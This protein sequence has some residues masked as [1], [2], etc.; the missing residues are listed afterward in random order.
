M[1]CVITASVF[2]DKVMQPG[3]R[4]MDQWF[5]NLSH[6]MT[7][8]HYASGADDMGLGDDIGVGGICLPNRLNRR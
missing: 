1:A 2:A 4:D 6:S 7:D 5:E 3:T 8:F